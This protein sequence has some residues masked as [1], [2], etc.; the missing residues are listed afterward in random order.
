MVVPVKS[1]TGK[2]LMPTSPD[3]AR[4]LVRKG[5]ATPFWSIGIF[6]IRMNSEMPNAQVQRV[7]AGVDPGSKKEGITILSEKRTFLNMQLDAV[8]HVKGALAGRREA[9]QARRY[10]GT[11]CRKC[12]RL[13]RPK[14]TRILPSSRARWGLKL[15]VLARLRLM[16]PIDT[17]IVEDVRA[18]KKVGGRAWN[19][20]FSY[21]EIG[22]NWF[23]TE[24]RRSGLTLLTKR[25]YET[26]ALR[27]SLGFIKSSN[28]LC[29][30]WE[31]HCVDS[32][33]LASSVF[34]GTPCLSTEMIMLHPIRFCRRQLHMYNPA[35]GGIR[36]PYGGTRSIGIRRGSLVLSQKF[37][38]CTVG[39]TYRGIRLSLHCYSSGERMCRRAKISEV[40]FLTYNRWWVSHATTSRNFNKQKEG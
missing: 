21:V 18:K 25:G 40:K 34:L 33:V 32:W 26:K 35:K 9:R 36:K 5:L 31:A 11:P 16:Y 39:G 23:Y 22:K 37:G 4:R 17:L 28:K 19:R 6:C 13:N 27:D 15:N 8:T 10:R 1:E 14:K 38:L 3:R 29:N 2:P 30:R 24:I 20:S 12:R 7:V